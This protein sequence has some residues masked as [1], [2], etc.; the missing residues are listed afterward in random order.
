MKEL[1]Y[2]PISNP[3]SLV[4]FNKLKEQLKLGSVNTVKNYIEYL[5]KSWL[6][7]TVNV[8]DYSVRR[9]QIASKKTYAIDTGLI[10]AVGFSFSPNRG[11]LLENLVFLSL[12]R[13]GRDIY[14]F[15]PKNGYE[16]DFYLPDR[17]V[18]IQ[19]SQNLHQ[20]ETRERETRSL[21]AAMTTLNLK[22]SLIL[23]EGQAESIQDGGKTIH[24]QPVAAWLL[25]A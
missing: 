23:S 6:I 17:G 22:E 8:Y 12:R 16:V 21:L 25:G 7:F 2:S 3:A 5:E 1:A 20:R 13:R 15:L 24:L 9:Q 19:V 18:L 4:S 14:Y 11:R 10:N